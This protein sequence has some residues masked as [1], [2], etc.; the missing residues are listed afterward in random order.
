MT[1][2]GNVLSLLLAC[3]VGVGP[4]ALL[5]ALQNR[6]D[7]R[8]QVLFHEVASQ[9]SSETLRSD[10]A[11]GVRCRL[12]S[13]GATVRLDLGRASAPHIWDTAARLRQ[14]LP[15]WA[16]LE[17][18]GQLDGPQAVPRP[19]RIIVESLEPGMLRRAA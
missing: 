1:V 13:R 19:L 4:V 18:D 12:L 6:R 3:V 10:V 14:G 5:A 2:L 8:A 9:L 11:L 16:R 15:A 17:V 7:R